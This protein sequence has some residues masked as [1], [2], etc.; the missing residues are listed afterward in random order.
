MCLYREWFD[1]YNPYNNSIILIGNNATCKTIGIWA[2]KVKM[3]DGMV[4]TLGKV[5]HYCKRT[6]IV[7]P[8]RFEYV[9]RLHIFWVGPCRVIM[10]LYLLSY[11]TY[12]LGLGLYPSLG[13]IWVQNRFF[14]VLGL[15]EH[16]GILFSW[17]KRESLF[18]GFF[19]VL[20]GWTTS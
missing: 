13:S 3:F 17:H 7:L 6:P 12:Y 8:I 19:W 4:R 14:M 1:T 15:W 18:K 10:S 2:I 5:R 11:V 20:L 9:C 16:V